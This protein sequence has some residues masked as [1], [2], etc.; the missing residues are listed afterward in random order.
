MENFIF[1]SAAPFWRGGAALLAATGLAAAAENSSRLLNLSIEELGTIKVDVV[2]AA[3]KAPEK[4]TDAPASVT[5]VTR[6]QISRFGYR[7]LGDIMRATRSFDVSYDRNYNYPGARGFNTIGDYGSHILLLV[8]GHRMNEPTY[9]TIGVGTEGLL[10]VDLIERVEF[11]RGPGSSL[12]GSNAVLAVINVVTRSGASVD[13]VETSASG[14]SY[15]TY[16]GRFT[17]GK[18][19]GNGLEYLLSGTTSA[20]E[21]RSR[22]YYREFDSP[23]TNHGIASHQDGDRHW[24]LLGK[25]S[26]DDFTLQGGYVTRDKNVPTGAFGSAF[27]KPYFTV[28]S[29]GYVELRYSHETANGWAVAGRASYDSYDYFAIRPYDIEGAL[30]RNNESLRAHWWGAEVNASRTFLQCFRFAFGI[31]ATQG[32]DIRQRNYDE[33]PFFSYF[34]TKSDRS[35]IGAYADGRIEIT[36]TLHLTAGLRWDRYEGLDDALNP[37]AALIWKPRESTSVK[38]L[39]GEAYPAPNESQLT[40]NP[41]DRRDLPALEAESIRTYEAVLEQYW[42]LRWRSSVSLFRNEFSGLIGTALDSEGIRYLANSGEACVV[43]AEAEIEGKWDNGLLLRASYT[44]QNAEN[45]QTG[46]RLL[47]SPENMLKAQVSVPLLRETIFVSAELLYASD[48]LTQTRQKTGDA[49]QLN[50]TLFSRELLPGLEFS[51]S[52]Y[53]L[54]DQKYGAPGGVEHLQDTIAQDGRGFRVK[55]N[56]RF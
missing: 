6:D 23:K 39:Y 9:D 54:L 18:R 16:T 12:Y 38:L 26:Y 31:E 56:Y 25:L 19:L 22:L 3:S 49:W 21:G 24:S 10:D 51:A 30:V 7:T 55:L 27:N 33:R 15:E 36:K 46:E 8:D 17:L 35:M 2:F 40:F 43:G 13:G 14:G 48:R 47:N 45:E 42:G 28:D 52:V 41:P 44:R 20:S 50:A 5:I 32:T 29:R 53:N 37:H 11:I 1:T 34:D 4:V